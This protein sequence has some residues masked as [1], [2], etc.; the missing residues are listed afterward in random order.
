VAPSATGAR[1]RVQGGHGGS[2]HGGR[3]Q[4]WRLWPRPAQVAMRGIFSFENVFA[5]S[6]E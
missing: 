3:G 4:A 5:A 1:G 6:E 2:G